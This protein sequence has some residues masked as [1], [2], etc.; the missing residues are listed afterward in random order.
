MSELDT[1]T[2]LI[3]LMVVDKD[4]KVLHVSGG[5]EVFFLLLPCHNS[6]LTGLDQEYPELAQLKT[7]CVSETLT[8]WSADRDQSPDFQHHSVQKSPR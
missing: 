5:E 2:A 8:K 6:V 4:L 7:N 1:K 3:S